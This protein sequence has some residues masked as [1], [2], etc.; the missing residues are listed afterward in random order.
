LQ[1]TPRQDPVG[2]PKELAAEGVMGENKHRRKGYFLTHFF[3]SRI[4]GVLLIS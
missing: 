4:I 1:E 3:V 2:I